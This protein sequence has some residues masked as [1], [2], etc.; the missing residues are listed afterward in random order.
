MKTTIFTFILLA[1]TNSSVAATRVVAAHSK[2]GENRANLSPE[3][4][5]CKLAQLKML[6]G[7]NTN[8]DKGAKAVI[9]R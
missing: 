9:A 1:M 8:D 4:T 7:K 3:M 2:L 5:H 6:G